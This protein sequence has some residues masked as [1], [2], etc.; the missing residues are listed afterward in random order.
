MSVT[1]HNAWTYATGN[2]IPLLRTMSL[3]VQALDEWI[4]CGWESL[5][6][7]PS[8]VFFNTWQFTTLSIPLQP[9]WAQQEQFENWLATCEHK[10]ALWCH[11]ESPTFFVVFE[12]DNDAM[13]FLLTWGDK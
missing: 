3:S 9:R 6:F 11:E 1:R 12:N 7:E 10:T 5:T 13:L 8:V 4:K 2:R